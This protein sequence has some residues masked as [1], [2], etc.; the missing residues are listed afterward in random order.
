MSVVAASPASAHH[1]QRMGGQTRQPSA[2]GRFPTT[3]YPGPT[4][5]PAPGAS[6][7]ESF[8]GTLSVGSTGDQVRAVEDKLRSLKYYVG[9]VDTNYDEDTAHGVTAFQKVEGMD[10]SG[11]VDAEVWNRIQSASSPG[12]LVGGSDT[13]VEIDLGRQVLFLYQG[14]GLSEILAVS[15]GTEVPYCEN[16]SC[17]DAVTPTG[18]FEIYRIGEGWESG[19]LGDL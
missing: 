13:R 8:S 18:D 17:G 4:P 3:P 10:R 15:T 16:G 2:P 6:Q 5:A 12:P 14:G 19:P 9:P 7:G 1:G 11:E